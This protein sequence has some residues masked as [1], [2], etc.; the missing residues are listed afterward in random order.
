VELPIVLLAPDEVC[1]FAD[2]SV[3]FMLP[4]VWPC[5]PICE[6]GLVEVDGWA[7]LELGLEGEVLC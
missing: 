2:G 7:V 5:A 6:P 4:L 1:P 3:L